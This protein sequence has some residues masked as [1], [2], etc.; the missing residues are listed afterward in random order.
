M[1]GT[2][3][4]TMVFSFFLSRKK[5]GIG[6]F[7]KGITSVITIPTVDT[8]SEKIYGL[9]SNSNDENHLEK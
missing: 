7:K 9:N 1:L 6:D 3:N 8:T 2:L 4:Y 5:I